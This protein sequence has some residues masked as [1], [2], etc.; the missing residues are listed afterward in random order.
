[1]P[2]GKKIN[3][4][5]PKACTMSLDRELFDRFRFTCEKHGLDSNLQIEM[6]MKGVIKKHAKEKRMEV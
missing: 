6:F 3:G 2:Q 4:R 1:M 5:E